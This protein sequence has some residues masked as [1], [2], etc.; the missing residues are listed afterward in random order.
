MTRIEMAGQLSLM[1]AKYVTSNVFCKKKKKILLCVE[2]CQ[3]I[4]EMSKF[5]YQILLGIGMKK[6][7]FVK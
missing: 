5:F 7:N 2:I 6:V 3:K 1:L 4:S